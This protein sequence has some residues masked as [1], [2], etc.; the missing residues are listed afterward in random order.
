MAEHQSGDRQNHQD[1]AKAQLGF[2]WHNFH[3]PCIQKNR[4]QNAGIQKGEGVT[5]TG[6][7]QMEVICDVSHHHPGDNYQRACQG[8]GEK[9]NP[10]E[11][12]AIAVSHD[13][14]V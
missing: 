10:C 3:Q 13:W 2:Q 9:A 12:D 8:V 1:K 7:G 11:L 5:H 6:N 14:P 4:D